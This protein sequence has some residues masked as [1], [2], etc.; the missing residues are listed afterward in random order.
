MLLYAQSTLIRLTFEEFINNFHKIL[1]ECGYDFG[2]GAVKTSEFFLFEIY[3]FVS[4]L[5]YDMDGELRVGSMQ[6]LHFRKE[7]FFT[8]YLDFETRIESKVTT[9]DESS[10]VQ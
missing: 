6:S 5:Y 8:P 2:A 7:G 9:F 1:R 4:R 10:W 3:F